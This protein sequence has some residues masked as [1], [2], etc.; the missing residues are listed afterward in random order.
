MCKYIYLTSNVAMSIP[1]LLLI[2]FNVLVSYKGFSESPFFERYKFSVLAIQ[3]QQYFRLLSSGFLHVDT[4]HLIFNMF[5]LYIF[6]DVVIQTTGVYL[7]MMIY[8]LSLWG[9]NYFTYVNH[10]NEPSYS[11]VGASGAV[12]GI[13]YSSILL[14]PQMQLALIFFPIP[15]PGYVFGILYLLYT[16]FGMKRRIDNIGHTAHFGGAV[17]GFAITL[18]IFPSLIYMQTNLILLMLIPLIAYMVMKTN[19]KL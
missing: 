7:F 4:A 6:G 3:K 2:V 8:I 14:F 9:G 10:K 12:S 18:F 16:L 15:M 19:G 17:S 1:V 5:A 11:A 13:V